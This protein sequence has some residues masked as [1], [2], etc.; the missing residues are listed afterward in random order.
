MAEGALKAH[1]RIVTG[2]RNGKSVVLSDQRI[3]AYGFK[4]VRGFEHTY[5]WATTGTKEVDPEA[6][7][8]ELAKSALP[9]PGGSLVQIVTFPPATARAPHAA[10]PSAIAQEYRARLPGLADAFEHD[11][12]QMHVTATL[13]YAIVL[14]GKL[15]LE[16]DDGQIVHLETGD[17][18]VQ[19]ATRHGWRN[20]G[21]RPATIAF[22]MLAG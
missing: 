5:V 9:A 18:V 15:W 16:L 8:R 20:M 3:P 12:S 21:E 10:D 1:R 13:D 22:V 19:Q 2:H 11:G 7:E 4:T 14:D 6:V 17:I